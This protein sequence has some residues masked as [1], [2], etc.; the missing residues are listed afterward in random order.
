MSIV[1]EASIIESTAQGQQHETMD[2]SKSSRFGCYRSD[3][4]GISLHHVIEA[5][6]AEGSCPNGSVKPGALADL[7]SGR[8]KSR[9][10]VGALVP[11]EALG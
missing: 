6:F 8:K 4:F 2:W 3:R 11:C 1:R 7:D 10:T 5:T 9:P